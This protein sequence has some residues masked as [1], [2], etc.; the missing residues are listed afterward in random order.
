MTAWLAVESILLNDCIQAIES[1][2]TEYIDRAADQSSKK[3]LRKPVCQPKHANLIKARTASPTMA[4]GLTRRHRTAQCLA[5]GASE[6]G[7]QAK[8]L[9]G[10][11][12][13]RQGNYSFQELPAELQRRRPAVMAA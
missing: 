13:L 6:E 1:A 2:A 9:K 5:P 12:A 4:A 7:A 10:L 8:T 11:T 3:D